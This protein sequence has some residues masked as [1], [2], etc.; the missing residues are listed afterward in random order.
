MRRRTRWTAVA[1]V[2]AL[3]L[4]ACD[5][6]GDSVDDPAAPI[7]EQTDDAASTDGAPG[8]DGSDGG[9]G[10]GT[11]DP[12]ASGTS[13]EGDEPSRPRSTTTQ[14]DL[15]APASSAEIRVAEIIVEFDGQVTDE[16]T[17]L[18]LE[19]PILFDFDS[20]TLRSGA[21]EA[22]DDIAEVLAYYDGAPVEIVGHTDDV[23]SRDYNLQLSQDRAAAVEDALVDRDIDPA[24][25]SS[26][27]RAFDE[28][29]ASN[30]TD[31]GRATN[32]RVEVLVV[33]VEP[34]ET[35]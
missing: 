15:D 10:D 23:G 11:G 1:V 14:Q 19:E 8:D 3:A 30:D 25:L 21:G 31:E 13:D 5:G 12:Q 28:P 22:L 18:T 20:A 6:E 27:G 34:P 2:C 26:E 32:R 35:D 17:V 16:G 4:T 33:G 9:T 7:E 29:V 24:R